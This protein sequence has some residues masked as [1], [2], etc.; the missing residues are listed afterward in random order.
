MKDTKYKIWD[1]VVYN[2]KSLDITNKVVVKITT[3]HDNLY[4]WFMITKKPKDM[5]ILDIQ[6]YMKPENIIWLVQEKLLLR[7][8]YNIY[9]K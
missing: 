8:K 7:E 9:L 1:I 4:W 5:S 2:S 3:I 6:Y